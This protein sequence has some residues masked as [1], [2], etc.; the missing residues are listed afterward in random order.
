MLGFDSFDTNGNMGIN[1]SESKIYEAELLQTPQVSYFARELK[2]RK[3]L[4]LGTVEVNIGVIE[5]I[6]FAI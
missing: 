3:K 6:L 2:G 5:K 4:D 1:F